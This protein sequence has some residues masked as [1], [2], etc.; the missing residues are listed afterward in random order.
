MIAADWLLSALPEALRGFLLR[1]GER[2]AGADPATAA[3]RRA[4]AIAYAQVV[5]HAERRPLDATPP[6]GLRPGWMPAAWTQDQAGRAWLLA[7][8]PAEPATVVAVLDDLAARADLAELVALYQALAIVPCAADLAGRVA[9][10]VRSN[11]QA[12]YAAIALDHPL[13]AE[14]LDQGAWNQLVLKGFF[15][16]LPTHR[17][18][19]WDAR[20]NPDL[21]RMLWQ[22]AHERRAAGR[23]VPPG[24]WRG[25]APFADAEQVAALRDLRHSTDPR[26]ALAGSLGLA[27]QGEGTA[28]GTWADVDPA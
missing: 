11:I 26:E 3:G 14:V 27:A 19:G 25:I 16:G 5:R 22:Y 28:T 12:V 23:P 6:E 10:G 17:I 13:P 2:I 15:L 8:L 24:L 1:V 9:E 21:A 20:A 4:L 7:R 18:Q